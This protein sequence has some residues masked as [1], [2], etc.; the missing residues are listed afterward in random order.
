M[1]TV[2]MMV[3]IFLVAIDVTVVG[4]AMP[5]IVADL[6]GLDLISWVFAVYTLT[7]T[8][9]TPI[10][11]K[12]AD[13]FGRRI[14]F[15]VGVILFVLGS[16]LSGAAHTMGQ[17]IAFRAFQGIGAGAVMPITFTIIG[18]LYPGEQ[19]ARMQGLFSSVWG[20]AGLVGPLVGGFFVDH[21]SWRWIFYI[22]LP[23][24]VVTLILVWLG[25][26]ERFDKHTHRI[27][28][29]GAVT[30]TAGVSALLYA[31]LNGG[32]RYAWTSGTI[33]GLFAAAIVLMGLFIWIERRA[34]EPMVPLHLFRMRVITAANIVGFL[35]SAA[36]IGVTA[37][38]PL[39]IQGLLGYS[40]TNSGLT[41]LPMSIGWPI[42]STVAGRIM[43]RIG[44]KVTAV[45]G[46][47]LIAAGTIWLATVTLATPG[48]LFTI[49]MVIIGLGMGFATTPT[50]VL[51]QSAVGWNLRGAATA[52]STFT[53]SLGQSVGIAVYGTVFN[54]AIASY[55]ATHLPPS[56]HLGGFDP[57]RAL[58]AETFAQIPPALR[59]A[60]RQLLAHG[61]HTVFL[62]VV[63]TGLLTLLATFLLPRLI[64][65]GGKLRS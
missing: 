65:R 47:V 32:T 45:T 5:R 52:T 24:G 60:V 11:G 30:F 28:V 13:L 23:V 54:Q 44:P 46:G 39:W 14:V 2:A 63:G 9:T 38:L 31:L 18:D 1:V 62:W 4:T 57:S 27:D 36:L 49:I 34:A 37:W 22:N 55:A 35:S 48:W 15:T 20:I 19:R 61:L 50:P 16:M 58:N 41:L 56:V 40:A 25:L 42:G 8:V 26:H 51:I 3:A 12:L 53:R 21:A 10:Y 59:D 33:L 64:D 43:Y 7:T 17:L 29:W 6:G